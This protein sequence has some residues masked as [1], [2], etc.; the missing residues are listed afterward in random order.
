MTQPNP[1]D[2]DPTAAPTDTEPAIT[3][4]V[5]SD[6]EGWIIEP[7]SPRRGWMDDTNGFAY[8]C[9]PL[10]IANQAGW[11]V[12]CPCDV[13][14]VWNGGDLKTDTRVVLPS[15]AGSYAQQVTSHFGW[16]I[17]TFSIPWVF[18]TPPGYA[19]IVRGPTNFFLPGLA[20]LDGIV[21]TDW[22]TSTFTMN[23][24]VVDPDREVRFSMGDPICMLIPYRVDQLERFRPVQMRLES[25][26]QLEREYRTWAESRR[27][28]NANPER[29]AEDWQKDYFRGE[30]TGG[31]KAREHRSRLK[32]RKFDDL[33]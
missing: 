24:Q 29:K 11:V 21:E 9:L 25:N 30:T 18:R 4:H 17:I 23:W 8:R 16:G 5:V 33:T 31:S 27:S 13:R 28:F 2:T 3:A 22:A 7:G 26:P 6:A 12:R 1:Q 15:G 32:L 14:A 20:A 19:L 10:S